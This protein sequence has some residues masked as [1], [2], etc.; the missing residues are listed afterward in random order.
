MSLIKSLSDEKVKNLKSLRYGATEPLVTKDINKTPSPQGLGLEA[1]TRKDDLKRISKLLISPSG[2]RYLGSEA[3]L[4][5]IGLKDRIEKNVEK[6]RKRRKERVENRGRSVRN[7]GGTIAGNL[8][9]AGK[10]VLEEAGKTA[11]TTAGIVGSTLAQVPVNGTGTHFFRGFIGRENMYPNGPFRDIDEER[12][13]DKLKTFDKTYSTIESKTNT[14]LDESGNRITNK[15]PIPKAGFLPNQNPIDPNTGLPVADQGFDRSKS[16]VLDKFSSFDN[17]SE[18]QLKTSNTG[19]FSTKNTDIKIEDFRKSY[20]TE[21]DK[22]GDRLYFLDYND[23]KIK[24]ETRVNL[25]DQGRSR[26]N[27]AARGYTQ[28]PEGPELDKINM[29]PPIKLEEGD[30]KELGTGF[31][32]DL[33]KFRFEVIT[34]DT[35]GAKSTM[36]YFRA[37]LDSFDDSYNADW[38]KNSY[39]GRGEAF[40]TYGGFDRSISLSFKIA[41][42][43][44]HEMQPLYQK[45]VFLASSTAPT[46]SANF[47]RGTLVNL[48]VGDYV[49][50]MPGFIEQI[51]YSWETDYPWEIAMSKPEGKGQDDDMQELP[52]VLNCQVNFKPIHPF[53]PQTGL[54]HYITNPGFGGKP[55]SNLFFSQNNKTEPKKSSEILSNTKFPTH[56]VP[57]E[58]EAAMQPPPPKDEKTPEEKARE[59]GVAV[60]TSRGDQES[61]FGF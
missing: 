57:T 50:N 35:D 36:L 18:F 20:F 7:E 55:K 51:N 47:M 11:L 30:R 37:F 49:Y 52:H 34:P 53:T 9:R 39:L 10:A 46:Y 44:R 58:Q 27:F 8:L 32:R 1:S 45:M 14:I 43:T 48:T 61:G 38:S 24:R 3:L 60:D 23:T 22:V 19:S 41:A 6:Q 16:Q 13:D 54:Y 17:D 40:Y 59:T 42:A 5:Q 15:Y 31:A 29:L 12:E 21:N 2:L 26:V 33:I 4:Q 28:P 56:L 25:G